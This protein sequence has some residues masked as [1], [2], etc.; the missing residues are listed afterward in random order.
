[1]YSA[2]LRFIPESEF[3]AQAYGA[4][5]SRVGPERSEWEGKRPW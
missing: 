5:R 3:E 1:M 4:F 2:A